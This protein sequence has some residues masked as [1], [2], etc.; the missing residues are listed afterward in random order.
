[1]MKLV[2]ALNLVNRHAPQQGREFRVFLACGFT[3]LHLQTF[4]TAELI[5]RMPQR[6]IVVDSGLY[7]DLPG[8]LQRAGDRPP[9]AVAVVI[10]WADLDPR[11]GYRSPHGGRL[12]HAQDVL[13]TASVRLDQ[14]GAAISEASRRVSVSLALPSLPLPAVFKSPTGWGDAAAFAI[15]EKLNGFAAAL[16]GQPRVRILD[17][18]PLAGPSPLHERLDLNLEFGS[19]FPYTRRHASALGEA[20]AGLIRPAT[21]MK[22]IITDL[23]DTLWR[24]ILGEDGV[25]GVSWD[26]DHG[27]QA[28]ALYQGM[29]MSLVDLGVLVA[30]ASKNDAKLVNRALQRK[31]LV[32]SAES[33]FPIEANWGPKSSSVAAILRTW[34]IGADS[35]AF[36]DDSPMELAEVAAAFPQIECLAFPAGDDHAVAGFL[37]KLR[38][39]FGKPAVTEEDRLRTASIRASQGRERA[40][41]GTTPD[42]FLA[43]AESEIMLHFDR[44]DRRTFEL[45][46][47]TNQFNL[48]GRRI[49]ETSFKARTEDS[50][51]F[52]VSASYADKFGP[53]G[54]IAVVSGRLNGTEPVVDV[55]VMSC[56]AFSRRIEHQLLKAL[57]EKFEADSIRLEFSQTERNGPLCDFLSAVGH[58]RPCGPTV[59]TRECFLANSPPLYAK[60]KVE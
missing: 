45:I 24:G 55:W 1:M 33:L 15:W 34:N 6:S 12:Q 2:E 47:K 10:E 54:K 28:H 49:D 20:L 44:P 36:V 56:R 58:T 42:E 14:L 41:A 9:D 51:G 21:P 48:N 13:E 53:L 35:V 59:I 39:L 46:N 17:P 43:R 50:R 32:V 37:G 22:G 4:L 27:S 16:A 7:G 52:L 3:P 5:E 57:F 8:N 25:E 38:E 60:V 31:D 30:V 23:D 18:Q 19:G 40:A 11:L 29:L 26:L